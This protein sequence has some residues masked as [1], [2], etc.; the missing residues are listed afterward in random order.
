MSTSAFL[1]SKRMI[2]IEL[3]K[4]SGT[5]TSGTNDSGKSKTQIIIF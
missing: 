2:S 1:S 5:Y 4:L 3:K